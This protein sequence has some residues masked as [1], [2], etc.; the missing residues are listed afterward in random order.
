MCVITSRDGNK[1][2]VCRGKGDPGGVCVRKYGQPAD[3]KIG[4]EQV[5]NSNDPSPTGT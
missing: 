3:P 2:V 5:V 4:Q 1:E